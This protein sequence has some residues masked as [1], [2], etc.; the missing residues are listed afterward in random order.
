MIIL[1]TLSAGLLIA[2]GEKRPGRGRGGDAV[3]Y[4]VSL[5]KTLKAK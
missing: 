2:C 1:V 5:L 4:E 3:N